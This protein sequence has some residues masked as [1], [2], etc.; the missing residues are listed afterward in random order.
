MLVVCSCQDWKR[1]KT[2]V[3]TKRRPNVI[4]L[5]KT[6]M[7][8]S[9][10][11]LKCAF[12]VPPFVDIFDSITLFWNCS[13]LSKIHPLHNPRVNTSNTYF[14]QKCFIY[15]IDVDG[16][17]SSSTRWVGSAPISFVALFMF[18]NDAFGLFYA[19]V[20]L[21]PIFHI[22]FAISV[23]YFVLR[24][25]LPRDKMLFSSEQHF[26]FGIGIASCFEDKNTI[27]DGGSTAP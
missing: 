20:S 24:W 21:A 18:G 6:L 27:R 19:F 26:Y 10:Y 3:P 23:W 1:K 7:V 2:M 25:R 5:H 16:P 13:Q 22:C 12:F 11:T 14:L 9:G 17:I 15:T 8:F 4:F